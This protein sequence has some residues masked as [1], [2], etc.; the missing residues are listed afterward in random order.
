LCREFACRLLEARAEL[1][2]V[3][4]FLG[5]V[6]ITTTSRYLRSTTL[7]LERALSLLEQKEQEESQN[8][9]KREGGR[10]RIAVPVPHQCHTAPLTREGTTILLTRKLLI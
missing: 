1:H 10:R 4:D 9:K 5:H 7:R 8:A 3:R 6:N 2:D